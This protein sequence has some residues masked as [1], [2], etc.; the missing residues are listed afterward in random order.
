MRLLCCTVGT[1]LTLTYRMLLVGW[2]A[3]GSVP[4]PKLT[5]C[6]RGLV[7]GLMIHVPKIA[8]T[9]NP[10]LK[11]HWWREKGYYSRDD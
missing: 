10:T 7:T 8:L 11:T 1:Y 2:D 4:N 6:D 5:H 3:N 9:V